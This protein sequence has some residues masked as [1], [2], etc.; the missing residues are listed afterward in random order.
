[1][2]LRSNYK[3]YGYAYQ[4]DGYYLESD[5]GEEQPALNCV[6]TLRITQSFDTC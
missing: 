3:R 1:M 5:G 2:T 6:L 4:G